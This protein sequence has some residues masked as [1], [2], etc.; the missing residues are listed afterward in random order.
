[1]RKILIVTRN[2][3]P[4]IG[5]MEKLNF[6]IYLA[7]KRA[8]D[9]LVAGPIGSAK[10][11]NRN[12]YVEFAFKPLWLYVFSSIIKTT[13]FSLRAKPN[14]IFCGS[15]TS[16]IAGYVAARLCSAKLVCYLHGLDV[17]APS[18]VY[19][20]FF[21]PLIKKS[22]LV[23]VNSNHTRELAL[24]AGFSSQCLSLLS[25][26]VDMPEHSSSLALSDS[27][28]VRYEIGDK[29]Y[30][31]LAGRITARKGIVEFIE[32]VFVKLL[33]EKPGLI[34][35]I[36]GEEAHQ[37]AKSSK[38][39]MRN[40][41]KTI[42][43]FGIENSII[44]TGAVS[45]IEFS[46]ALFGAELFVFPVLDLPNDVEGF[47]MVAIEAAAHGVPTVAF[48]SGGVPDAVSDGVSGWLVSPGDYPVMVNTI[49]TYLDSG[50]SSGVCPSSCTRFAAQYEWEKFGKKL[51]SIIDR[52]A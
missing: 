38:G 15:G 14:V 16:I 52:S 17:I 45:D 35:V 12:Q 18:Y 23:I 49:L 50:D 40:I 41:L 27:F 6:N 42:D 5:G 3:P 21:I 37:A 25:P 22:D 36:V 19:Q 39:V 26:G 46:G 4:L 44:L 10:F 32:N 13:L 47:G 43:K 7:L 30:L 24:K 28:R 34:L 51:R 8:Y 29:Q 20:A 1:M 33:S 48:A 11:L 31:L 2:F 9:V